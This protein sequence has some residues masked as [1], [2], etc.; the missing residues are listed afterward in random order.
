MFQLVERAG[1]HLT[2]NVFDGPW[3]ESP[4]RRRGQACD[5]AR[6]SQIGLIADVVVTGICL[7]MRW[8]CSRRSR[9]LRCL[10]L[11]FSIKG[12]VCRCR[13]PVQSGDD[14]QISRLPYIPR[15]LGSSDLLLPRGGGFS[16]AFSVISGSQLMSSLNYLNWND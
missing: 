11:P 7:G 12:L 16:D 9:Q 6:E 4:S 13:Q 5:W 14:G 8:R 3:K 2:I 10:C 1:K 15:F